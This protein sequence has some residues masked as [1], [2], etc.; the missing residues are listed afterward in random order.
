MVDDGDIA[1]LKINA[2]STPRRSSAMRAQFEVEKTLMSV[3]VSLAVARIS[4]SG[5]RSMA[6]SG[7]LCAGMILTLP[8]SS[9]TSWICP[10]D[11]PGNVRSLEPRQHS[12]R[13]LSAV[14]KTESFDGGEE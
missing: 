11:R 2:G 4:P 8:E 7:E 3:P 5:L 1:M 6:R 10:C 13:G 9:S 12:P 14:S